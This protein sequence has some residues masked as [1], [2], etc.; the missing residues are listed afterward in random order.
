MVASNPS[1]R[2]FILRHRPASDNDSRIFW[3]D[4]VLILYG[5]Q[6]EMWYLR[7]GTSCDHQNRIVPADKPFVNTDR[8]YWRVG[9]RWRPD[10]SIVEAWRRTVGPDVKYCFLQDIYDQN[11]RTV[12]WQKEEEDG[13]RSQYVLDL[14]WKEPGGTIDLELSQLKKPYERNIALF[15]PWTEKKSEIFTWI[16]ASPPDS[17]LPEGWIE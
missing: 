11:E 10:A 1:L 16:T 15:G 13:K 2:K 4:N 17:P 14:E 5:R 6:L 9:E 7:S 3:A 12:T 8:I